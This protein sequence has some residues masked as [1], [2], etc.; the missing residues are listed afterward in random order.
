MCSYAYERACILMCLVT[1]VRPKQ[2]EKE[3]SC[4]FLLIFWI[5]SL[6][7]KYTRDQLLERSFVLKSSFYIHLD[8]IIFSLLKLFSNCYFD[9]ELMRMYN[10]EKIE[11]IHH[12]LTK[13][14]ELLL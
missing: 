5:T 7:K 14:G 1:G 13:G 8:S 12:T 6:L 9:I 2:N 3:L 4:V 11:K 10:G